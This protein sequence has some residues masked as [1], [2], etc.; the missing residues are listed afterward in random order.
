MSYNAKREKPPRMPDAPQ[1]SLEI[2]PMHRPSIEQV[3]DVLYAS[4]PELRALA[5]SVRDSTSFAAWFSAF[6]RD[7]PEPRHCV[8]GIVAKD[9]ID[10]FVRIGVVVSYDPEREAERDAIQREADPL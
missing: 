5:E 2:T 4:R 10:G 9:G 8:S 7:P 6:R 1:H 3:R